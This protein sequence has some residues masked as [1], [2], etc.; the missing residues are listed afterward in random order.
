MALQDNGGRTAAWLGAAFER[1]LAFTRSGLAEVTCK[2]DHDHQ[3]AAKVY[4]A[5]DA[6]TPI[7]RG[8]REELQPDGTTLGVCRYAGWVLP[9]EDNGEDDSVLTLTSRA[10]L[11]RCEF[12]HTA[13]YQPLQGQATA[14]AWQL[15]EIAQQQG[16]L[17]I[18]RGPLATT[19]EHFMEYEL[20]QIAEA[21]GELSD[22]DPGFDYEEVPLDFADGTRLTRFDTFV[23]Q[24]SNR[25]N[26]HFG[27]GEGTVGNCKSVRRIT[28]VPRNLVTV[29]GADGVLAEAKDQASIDKYGLYS[30]PVAMSD[31][32]EQA[33]L[34]ARADAELEPDPVRVVGF[35]PNPA[36]APQLWTKYWLGDTVQLQ[37]R[38]GHFKLDAE[39]RIDGVAITLD[40]EG[41][42]AEHAIEI[43]EDP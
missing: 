4:S 12:R 39:P 11:G 15:I 22:L 43:V 13:V 36:L 41:F 23:S 31:V 8:F 34:Q 42:E 32:S 2:L 35:S 37:V 5:I 7:L 20:K 6:G 9:L 1:R 28:T 27:Y 21:V 17:G 26:V 25:P 16:D 10:P 14:L 40:D 19:N 33:V 30:H 3:A 38:D 29:I 18:E 24:G